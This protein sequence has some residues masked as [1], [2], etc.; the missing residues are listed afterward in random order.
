MG[1][2]GRV[3]RFLRERVFRRKE[4]QE[5]DIYAIANHIQRKHGLPDWAADKIVEHNITEVF[6]EKGEKKSILDA[7]KEEIHG[8]IFVRDYLKWVARRA[9]RADLIDAVKRGEYFS[10]LDEFR[11]ADRMAFSRAVRE[12]VSLATMPKEDEIRTAIEIYGEILHNPDLAKHVKEALEAGKV[13]L[14]EEV[15]IEHGLNE[16]R[17]HIPKALG[18]IR[19]GMIKGALWTPPGWNIKPNYPISTR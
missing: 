12:L 11:E 7:D 17:A 16:R 6:D 15:I 10:Y 1:V 18:W 3:R 4:R 5:M 2:F 19:D 13:E 9:G 14:P 8:E